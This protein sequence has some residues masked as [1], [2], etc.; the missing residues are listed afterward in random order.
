VPAVASH[1]TL[2]PG[3]PDSFESDLFQESTTLCPET[4]F[5]GEIPG[6]GVIQ[7]LLNTVGRTILLWEVMMTL[8]AVMGVVQERR[9]HMEACL[10]EQL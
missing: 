6:L 1:I 4:I 7:D 10:Q 8:E 9:L 3:T 2:S 5:S